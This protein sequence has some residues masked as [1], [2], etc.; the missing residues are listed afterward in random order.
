MLS[1]DY[2]CGRLDKT[3]GRLRRRGSPLILISDFVN[4]LP[5]T[6]YD[7]PIRT[8]S[9]TL[10][11]FKMQ[12]GFLP[13]GRTLLGYNKLEDFNKRRRKRKERK[14]CLTLT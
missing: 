10:L 11:F 12:S 8:F 13:T 1:C 6:G 5:T 2:A 3:H 7:L 9:F 14:R 4:R